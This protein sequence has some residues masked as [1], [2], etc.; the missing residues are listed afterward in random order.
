MPRLN[1]SPAETERTELSRPIFCISAGIN[2]TGLFLTSLEV[3]QAESRKQ[4][5]KP[6]IK[7]GFHEASDRCFI[8][9]MA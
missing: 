2:G 5:N 9:S 7:T 4:K 3:E 1:A 6:L 8:F